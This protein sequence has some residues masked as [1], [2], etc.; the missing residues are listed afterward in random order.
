[1]IPE[2]GETKFG[3]RYV[4]A[5]GESWLYKFNIDRAR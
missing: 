4:I 5:V 3:K 1:M 2:I